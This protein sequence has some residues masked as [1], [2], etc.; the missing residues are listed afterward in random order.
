MSGERSKDWAEEWSACSGTRT[1]IDSIITQTITATTGP[2]QSQKP[3]N[4]GLAQWR[5]FFDFDYGRAAEWKRL[6]SWP[7]QGFETPSGTD[8]F[9]L[10]AVAMCDDGMVAHWYCNP[11]RSQTTVRSCSGGCFDFDHGRVAEWRRLS[12][13][14]AQGF[15][16]PPGT[17]SIGLILT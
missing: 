11:G 8:S 2:I 14:L 12:S 10:E 5:E 1:Q 17:N 16:T 4:D 9:L 6:S 7:V 15:E 3:D 13:W